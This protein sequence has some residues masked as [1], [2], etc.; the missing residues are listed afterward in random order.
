MSASTAIVYLKVLTEETPIAAANMLLK[1]KILFGK[2][3][4]PSSRN[5]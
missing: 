2:S 1:G 3:I 5:L 4:V